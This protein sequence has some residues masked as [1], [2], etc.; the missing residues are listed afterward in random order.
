MSIFSV[1]NCQLLL[2]IKLQSGPSYL[3]CSFVV[4]FPGFLKVLYIISFLLL[5]HN[6][7]G[8]VICFY[9]KGYELGAL[10]FSA[11]VDLP[12]SKIKIKHF[13]VPGKDLSRVLGA[14]TS[15]K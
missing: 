11:G 8:L 9:L 6:H 2:V 4:L 7:S 3:L 10:S 5:N 13:Q 14:G 15:T 1:R 12:D